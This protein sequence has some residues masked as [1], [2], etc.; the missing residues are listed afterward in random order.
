VEFVYDDGG[1]AEAGYKGS[2][3]DCVVRA[4]AIATGRSYQTVYDDLHEAAKTHRSK[5]R[6][7]KAREKSASPRNGVPKQ[8][9]GPYLANMGW[10]WTPCMGIGT[11]CQVH[12]R[13]DELPPGR[14]ILRLSGHVAAVVDGVVHD[15]HDPSRDG[16]RCVYGYWQPRM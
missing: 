14:L 7:V 5:A 2:A 6:S 16:T 10:E 8:V 13:E 1:R 9:Y 12:V 11:G 4:I 15:T 3:N